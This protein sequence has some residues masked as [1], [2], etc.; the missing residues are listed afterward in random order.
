CASLHGHRARAVPRLAGPLALPVRHLDADLPGRAHDAVLSAQADQADAAR[1]EA[2]HPPLARHGDLVLPDAH[3]DRCRRRRQHVGVGRSDS[4]VA[5][6]RARDADRVRG[7]DDRARRGRRARVVAA[8]LALLAARA[9][10]DVRARRCGGFT[11]L[12]ELEP[13]RLAVRMRRFA[14]WSRNI[15]GPVRQCLALSAFILPQALAGQARGFTLEQALGYPYPYG[16]TAA[17]RGN[18]VAWV[19]NSRGSRNVWVADGPAFAGRQ[20]THYSGDDG[21]PIASLKLTPNGSTVVYARGSET[22]GK[23]EVADPTSNVHQPEQQVWAAD[24]SNGEP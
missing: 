9:F 13:A 4:D 2:D 21:M 5:Q 17:A 14:R 24:V 19:F 12:R 3:R 11:L 22:N 16:L 10:H 20:V 1:G 15:S 8:P 23:G 7:V 18:R 6:A